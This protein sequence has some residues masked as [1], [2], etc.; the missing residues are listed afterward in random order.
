MR[1][2][3][4]SFL[5]F[6]LS[7]VL[8][9]AASVRVLRELA[10]HG[11]EL[12]T[13]S[14]ARR[15]GITVQ[16]VRSTLRDLLPTR[17]L[18]VLGQ[19]RSSSYM[20]DAG[21]PVARMLIDL[22][23]AEDARVKALYASVAGA[24]GRVTPHPAAVWMYGSVARGEDRPGGDLDLLLVVD[25]EAAVA[26]VADAFRDEVAGVEAEHRVSISVVPVTR[27]DV[28][29]LAR[30]QDPFWKEILRDAIPLHG[31]PPEVLLSR[32][33]SKRTRTATVEVENG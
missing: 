13:G 10:L 18:T 27:S 16:A 11:G 24:A 8:P 30:T 7:T 14:L 21:H 4:Q 3:R 19:G 9:T 5:A 20:L 12:T 25:D 1:P 32:L 33:E 29:R 15:T 17:L 31:P 28:L 6:P 23:G 2:T 26:R 22:F